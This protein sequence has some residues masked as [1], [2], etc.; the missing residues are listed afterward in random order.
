MIQCGLV[1]WFKTWGVYPDCVVGHSSGEVAAAY[2]CGALSLQEATRL[3]FHR[4]TLQQRTAGSGRMLAIGLDRPG[5]EELLESLSLSYR[6][7]DGSATVEIACE[8]APA[9]TVICG[10]EAAL[11]PILEELERRNLQNSLIPGNIAFHSSAMDPIEED[12]LSALSF[13]NDNEFDADAPMVSSVTGSQIERLDHRYWWS[14]IRQPVRF[15]AAMDTIMRDYRPDVILEIAPHSALQT[16]IDQCLEATRL[17]PA[18]IPTLM[19]DTDVCIGIRETLGALFRVGVNLDFAAQFPRPEPI[20][21][22]LPGYPRDDQPLSDDLSDDEMFL[23]LGE[24]SH[25]PLVGH[26]VPCDHLLF[27]SR[28]SERDFPWLAEHRVHHASIMPAAGYI[29]LLLQAFEG[30]PLHIE[31]LEFLQPCPIPKTPVRLHTALFPV[32]NAPDEFTFTITSRS[33]EIEAQ[34]ELHSRGKVRRVGSDYPVNVPPHVTDIDTSA[35]EP[36][37]YMGESDFYERIDASLGE[38]FQYGPYFRNIKRVLWEGESADYLFDVEMDEDLWTTGREEGY[39]ANPALLDGGLQIFLYHL[40][41]ATDIFAMPRR[42]VGVT[43]LRPPTGPCLTCYV[44]KAKDW[45]DVNELGQF[46]ER[47]GERSGGSIRFYDG[48]TGDLVAC[49]DAY[50]SFNSNPRWNEFPQSKH[51]VS[52]QPKFLDEAHAFLHR[53][54]E[55]EVEPAALIAAMEQPGKGQ[56]QSC[57]VLEVAG[58]RPPE[59]TILNQCLDYLGSAAAQTEY[60]LTG[61][62]QDQVRAHYDA[63]Y[64]CDAA[65]RFACLDP[66]AEQAPELDTGLLRPQAAEILLLQ[67]NPATQTMEQWRL[68]RRLVVPGGLAL[69]L[70]DDGVSI[71]P[72]AGWTTVRAGERSTLLQAKQ[73]VD[74]T[75]P[76]KLPGPRWVIGQP[77]SLTTEWLALIDS[78]EVHFSS[79]KD[80]TEDAL[81]KLS[82]WPWASDLQ[83]IDYFFDPGPDDPTGLALVTR[84]VAFFKALIP[85]RVAQESRPCRMTVVTRRAVLDVANPGGSAVWGTLRSI[86]QEIAADFGTDAAIDFRLV[87]VDTAEDLHTLA[88]LNACDLRERELAIRRNRIWTP[89]LI[90]RRE[91]SPLLPSQE[92]TTYRL[93]LDNPGQIGGLQ[94]KTC[95]L[96]PLG[97]HDVEIEVAAAALNFRDVMVTLGLLPAHSYERSALGRTVGMEA[98]G[99][100]R[101]VG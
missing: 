70:H 98:S 28:M 11:S 45:A 35:F 39:I 12:A 90:N 65:L 78:P 17:A 72:K 16:T 2:A 63:F 14:N 5:V 7:E 74:A 86:S 26:R 19:R 71:E 67:D 88:F 61:N 37:Y 56:C 73:T 3:V 94:M 85:F 82:E 76:R 69:V 41:R 80:L 87:D 40:L 15:A 57:H 51:S 36:Y 46:T 81:A 27:E 8:N 34:S 64:N 95:H 93:V 20:A 60:W 9:S 96:Q 29:E 66:A 24:Y 101:R 59:E 92:E 18:S 31:T 89:R 53:L 47:R 4:A 25:G 100:V 79:V 55:G 83:A 58:E 54:P 49:I 23:K 1:E 97:P 6:P 42:A 32:P 48:A 33:Y 68:L 43:F 75:D 44:K 38:T 77:D 22:L 50:V 99:T 91:R 21:H 52:W 62:T 10:K 13:L 30:A 84:I